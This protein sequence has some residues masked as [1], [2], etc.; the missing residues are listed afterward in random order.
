MSESNAT[1][2]TNPDWLT[3]M[4]SQ[5]GETK[6]N[7]EAAAAETGKKANKE[8]ENDRLEALKKR[9]AQLEQQIKNLE[10]KNAAQQRKD[11]TRVKVLIGAAFLADT[12]KHPEIKDLIKTVVNRGIQRDKDREI[13]KKAGWL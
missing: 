11:E 12:L 3:A 6:E 1:P 10:Q 13:L 9:K 8:K 4:K 5:H 2:S 7:F